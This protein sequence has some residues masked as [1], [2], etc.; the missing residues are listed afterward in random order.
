MAGRPPLAVGALGN[1]TAWKDGEVWRARARTR[2]A[3]GE[4]K[5]PRSGAQRLAA[6][7]ECSI[8]MIPRIGQFRSAP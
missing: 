6:R 2:T 5:R 8:G 4:V 7:G 3:G 1:V